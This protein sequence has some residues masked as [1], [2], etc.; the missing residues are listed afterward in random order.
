MLRFIFSP[1]W[2]YGKDIVIDAFSLI[3]LFVVGF[4]G[5]GVTAFSSANIYTLAI[6]FISVIMMSGIGMIIG[7]I[8]LRFKHIGQTIP[9]IQGIAMFFCGVYF[10]ITILPI[11]LQHLAKFIPF[12]YSIEGMRLSLLV[13]GL[14]PRLLNFLIILIVLAIVFISLGILILNKEL[15]NAKRQGSLAFY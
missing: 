15:E 4:F 2:F 14:T 5:F 12:Y 9:L 13:D 11:P 10:P 6:F 8:T 7:G 1:E 3:V